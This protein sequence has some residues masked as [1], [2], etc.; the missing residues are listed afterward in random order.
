[1]VRH[2]GSW[3]RKATYTYGEYFIQVGVG[4]VKNIGILLVV[5]CY[6]LICCECCFDASFFCPIVLPSER[7]LSQ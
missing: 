6:P 4:K 3:K 2:A 1:M 5:S 7:V